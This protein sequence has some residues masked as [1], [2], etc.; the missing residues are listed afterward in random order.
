VTELT[1]EI[2][3]G[4]AVYEVRGRLDLVAA[5]KLKALIDDTVAGGHAR[6]IVDLGPTDFIDSSGLGAII[7]GLKTAREAGG[8]LRLAGVAGQVERAIELMKLHRVF[9]RYPT[10]EDAVDA[11]D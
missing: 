3:D 8:D 4:I 11:F 7:G 10:V 2:R 9:G 5:P 1:T 6:G